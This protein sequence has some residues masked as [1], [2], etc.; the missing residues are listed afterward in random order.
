MT[1]REAIF[2]RA[3]L[4]HHC[5]WFSIDK[6]FTFTGDHQVFSC[7]LGPLVLLLRFISRIFGSFAKKDLA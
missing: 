7:L 1:T 6:K 3:S 4:N 5:Q 2:L